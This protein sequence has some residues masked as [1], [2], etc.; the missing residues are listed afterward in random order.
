MLRKGEFDCN[1]FY[2]LNF[3]YNIGS[4]VLNIVIFV[5]G[6]SRFCVRVCW[7]GLFGG[8]L[9]NPAVRMIAFRQ[10]YFSGVEL[11]WTLTFTSLILGMAIVGGLSK[12]LITL[13]AKGSIGYVLTVVIIRSAA[14]IVTGLLLVLRSSTTTLVEVALMKFNRELISVDAMDI[15]PY[16]YIYFPRIL[17]GVVSMLVLSTYFT[18]VSIVGGYTLLSFQLDTT[19]DSILSQVIYDISLLD[20]VSFLFQSTLIGF[21]AM[22]IPIY[23]AIE[24]ENSQTDILKSF[25][26]GMMRLFFAFVTIVVL[27]ELI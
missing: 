25:V 10:I 14:P 2:M 18:V 4:N 17:A 8:K 24:S 12:L 13:G 27:G 6:Y 15:D 5:G 26:Y 19:L 9:F 16:I 3:V 11:F 20:V 7:R 22:S 1:I 23:T 21:V